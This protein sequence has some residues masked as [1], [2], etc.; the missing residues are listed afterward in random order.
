MMC[1]ILKIISFKNPFG[2]FASSQDTDLGNVILEAVVYMRHINFH[3]FSDDVTF[4]DNS[5][6]LLVQLNILGHFHYIIC[7]QVRQK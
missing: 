5:Q 7:C 4:S 6:L 1:Y 2:K 3:F